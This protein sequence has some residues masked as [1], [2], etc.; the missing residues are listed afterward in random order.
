MAA[1]LRKAGEPA[2]AYGVRLALGRAAPY[3][4]ARN[5][6]MV[7]DLRLNLPMRGMLRCSILLVFVLAAGCVTGVSRPSAVPSYAPFAGETADTWLGR[8]VRAQSLALP[9]GEDRPERAGFRLISDGAEALAAR[10]VLIDLAERSID[11]QYYIFNGDTSGSLVAERLL[12]AADRGVRVRLLLDDVG[13]GMGDSRLV[14]LAAHPNIEIRLFNPITLRSRWLAFM[15]QV[16]EFGRINYRMHNKLMVVDNQVVITGGRNIGDEYFS[17]EALDFQ[18]IDAIGIGEV[19]ARASVSF[20]DYWNSYLAVPVEDV[21]PRGVEPEDLERLRRRLARLSGGERWQ[22]L[23]ASAEASG[24]AAALLA[25][26]L[27]WHW[28]RFEW[29]SD[30]AAKAD[31][32]S[33]RS[34]VPYLG[35]ALFAPLAETHEELLIVSPY[36]VPSRVGLG[37][38]SELRARDVHVAVL[39]NSLA[40]TDVIAAHSAYAPY[41]TR[42]LELD[43]ELWELRMLAGQAERASAFGGS[44]LASLHAKT[45]VYDRRLLFIGSVNLD[46]RSMNLNTEAGVLV[47]QPE[48]AQEVRR[49][50]DYWTQAGQAFRLGVDD[51]GLRWEAGDDVE[52]GAEPEASW[53]RRTVSRFIGLF[54]IESQM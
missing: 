41:R 7:A 36:F 8:Y 9:A 28:G 51:R 18:D 29:I 32:T 33:T 23:L 35:E 2:Y 20:D 5:D 14:R 49:L 21:S 48:L 3:G 46:P 54:P 12:A 53:L 31:P 37:L 27:E 34:G 25:D 43:V 50:F 24:F 47:E 10:L 40:S 19:G 1:R 52:R 38:L 22:S 6:R 4:V 45:Y 26:R 11:L 16:G 42:L 39:T 30:P 15:S 44:S 13:A 17:F